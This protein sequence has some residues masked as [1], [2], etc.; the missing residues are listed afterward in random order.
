MLIAYTYLLTENPRENIAEHL[1]FIIFAANRFSCTTS[2]FVL[3]FKCCC[4]LCKKTS[5][6]ENWTTFQDRS[7]NMFKLWDVLTV[8]HGY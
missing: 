4:S 6:Y 5:Q 1:I 8:K 3:W 7:E 2:A